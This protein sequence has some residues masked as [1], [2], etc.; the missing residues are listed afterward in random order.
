M[1]IYRTIKRKCLCLVEYINQNGFYTGLASRWYTPKHPNLVVPVEFGAARLYCLTLQPVRAKSG[2]HGQVRWILLTIVSVANAQ[3]LSGTS[4]PPVGSAVGNL[5]WARAFSW[6][7]QS[8]N[9]EGVA[10]ST[11]SS[12]QSLSSKG[13]TQLVLGC[14]RRNIRF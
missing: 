2:P 14:Q 13:M 12:E 10:Q 1:Q 3:L 11:A 9:G 6:C 7:E 5:L 8:C 4:A